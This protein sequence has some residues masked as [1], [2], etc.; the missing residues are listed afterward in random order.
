MDKTCYKLIKAS[1]SQADKAL[2]IF[3]IDLSPTSLESLAKHIARHALA[4]AAVQPEPMDLIGIILGLILKQ[5]CGNEVRAFLKAEEA[6][7]AAQD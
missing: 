5:T 2:E 7:N 4:M 6:A 1:I 3:K